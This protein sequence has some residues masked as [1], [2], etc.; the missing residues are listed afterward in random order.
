MAVIE[1]VVDGAPAA[2][3]TTDTKATKKPAFIP[4]DKFEVGRNVALKM[5]M[6]TKRCLSLPGKI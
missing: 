5:C 4:A 2:R 1:E 6:C 3:Q